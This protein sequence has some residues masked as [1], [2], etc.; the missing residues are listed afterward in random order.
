MYLS[1][2]EYNNRIILSEFRCGAVRIFPMV[3]MVRIFPMVRIFLRVLCDYRTASLR[4]SRVRSKHSSAA[5][6]RGATIREDYSGYPH[7][8]RDVFAMFIYIRKTWIYLLL[9]LL[10]LLLKF[11]QKYIY[12]GLDRTVLGGTARLRTMDRILYFT[13]PVYYGMLVDYEEGRH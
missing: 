6:S 4:Y 9:L 10:L 11:C 7:Y 2:Y 13:S 1:K 3:R 8:I 12:L 5:V